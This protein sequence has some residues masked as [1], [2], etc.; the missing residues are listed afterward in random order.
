VRRALC[1]ALV[2]LCGLLAGRIHAEDAPKPLVILLSW[3]GVRHDYPDLGGVPGLER[4]IRDGARAEHLVAGWPSSTFP[5]HV[6][7]ATGAWADVHGIV[8]NVFFDRARNEEV[9][10]SSDAN[11]LDAEPLWIAAERQ[12]VKAATYFWV[13]SEG[14]WKGRRATFRVAPFDASTGEDVKLA[15]IVE[16]IDLPA[17]QR[18]GLIM[19]WWHGTDNAGHEHGPDDPAVAQALRAQDAYLVQLLAA[20]DARKLWPTTTLMIVSDHG[21][22]AIGELYDPLETLEA[23]GLH[24]RVFGGSA[25]NQVFLDDPAEA[26]EAIALFEADGLHAYRPDMLPRELHLLYPA[27]TGDL[28]VIADAPRAFGAPPWYMKAAFT[29]LHACCGL[30]RGAHGYDPASADM[31][32]VLLAMGRGVAAGTRL[33][34]VPQI[35]VAPTIARLLGIEAPQNATG[36]PIPEITGG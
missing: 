3:D 11:W 19:S 17:A 6:S 23:H 27:R 13:G 2:A 20:L 4:M 24:G 35:D 1:F 10:Y 7:I 32:A 16:W 29:A 33:G 26:D 36:K 5:G 22:T 30:N 15:Q 31:G 28:V 21:M 9:S 8:D 34:S 25:V 14:D 18:P 12:G